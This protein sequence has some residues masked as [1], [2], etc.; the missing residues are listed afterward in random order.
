MNAKKAKLKQAQGKSVES[1]SSHLRVLS[2]SQ[3][4]KMTSMKLDWRNFTNTIYG[5]MFDKI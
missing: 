4:K 3:R 2:P 5:E 1:T